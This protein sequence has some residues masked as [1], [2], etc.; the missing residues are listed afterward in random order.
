MHMSAVKA[1]KNSKHFASKG[2]QLSFGVESVM[3]DVYLFEEISRSDFRLIA[4]IS[5]LTVQ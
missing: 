5:L 4:V 2:K 1:R 3:L